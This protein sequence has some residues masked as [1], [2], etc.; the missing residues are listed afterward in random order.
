M[1]SATSGLS[2]LASLSFCLISANRWAHVRFHRVLECGSMFAGSGLGLRTP[3]LAS[4]SVAVLLV[5]PLCKKF[6]IVALALEGENL[7]GEQP[8]V[9]DWEAPEWLLSGGLMGGAAPKPLMALLVVVDLMPVGC[10]LKEVCCWC[11]LG[12]AQGEAGIV[13]PVR[14]S[15]A[16]SIDICAGVERVLERVSP[17]ECCVVGA[18]W[19]SLDL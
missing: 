17:F 15:R 11:L 2:P 5:L 7:F 12:S 4:F 14:S 19:M 16:P 9:C 3:D 18:I 13:S 1:Y 8:A 6:W 10:L